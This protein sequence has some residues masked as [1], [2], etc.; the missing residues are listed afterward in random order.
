MV[1]GIP[2]AFFLFF[3]RGEGL[4][5]RA[6]EILLVCLN[7]FSYCCADLITCTKIRVLAAIM[8]AMGFKQWAPPTR[9]SAHDRQC[10]VEKI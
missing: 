7:S 2:A 6:A 8:L 9:S 10:F 3:L 1:L 5:G 4:I